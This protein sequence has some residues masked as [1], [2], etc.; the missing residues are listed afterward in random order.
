MSV[1]RSEVEFDGTVYK[2][3]PD[4]A[5]SWEIKGARDMFHSDNGT[6]PRSGDT[7]FLG[8]RRLGKHAPMPCCATGGLPPSRGRFGAATS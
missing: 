1:C 6:A 2:H 4:G 8:C 7:A 5:P 3:I